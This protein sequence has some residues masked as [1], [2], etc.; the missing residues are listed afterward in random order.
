MHML[1]KASQRQHVC[2]V[3]LKSHSPS[4]SARVCVDGFLVPIF[5]IVEDISRC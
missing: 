1:L 4:E 5:T 3:R 2:D